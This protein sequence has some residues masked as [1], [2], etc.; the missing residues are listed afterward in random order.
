MSKKISWILG[1]LSI[2][3]I[4]YAQDYSMVKGKSIN[5]KIDLSLE[6]CI[7]DG[8][9]VIITYYLKNNTGKDFKMIYLGTST[10]WCGDED[11]ENTLV[12]DDLGNNY[13]GSI[14]DQRYNTYQE[15]NG[16]KKDR[17]ETHIN[18]TLPN[19][20]RVKGMYVI[21]NVDPLA[22]SFQVVNI[23]FTQ[24]GGLCRESSFSFKNLPI[25][26]Q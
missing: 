14:K 16:V 8:K 12:I 24:F 5:N 17:N 3:S 15:L 20:I 9:S 13:T 4:M 11:G 1:I 25:Y 2:C 23:A 7:W 26:T 6:S 18:V 22:K 19:G 21:Y 10:K